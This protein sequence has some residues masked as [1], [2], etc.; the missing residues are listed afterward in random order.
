M[1]NIEKNAKIIGVGDEGIKAL[2]SIYDRVK[3]NM[4]IEKITIRQDV[5]KEFVRRLLDGV[6]VL[7]LTYN[8]EDNRVKEIVKAISYMSGERRILCIGLNLS[9][10][11]NKDELGVNRDF[12]LSNGYEKVVNIMNIMIE[13][14]SDFCMINID[15]TDLKEVLASDKGVKYS[16]EE[17]ESIEAVDK[18]SNAILNNMELLGNE[19]TGKKGIVFVELN[20]NNCDESKMLIN[21]NEILT[22]IQEENDN[23]CELIFS[24]NIKEN[25]NNQSR[26]ALI[27]N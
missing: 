27:Y 12:N 24:L 9:S 21:L 25:D 10:K 1:E 20:K 26:I 4:D 3:E 13:S 17:I 8:T 23:S 6:E 11:E 15:L 5:D 18:I 22:K 7:F 2:D 19:I 16:Y 14:I